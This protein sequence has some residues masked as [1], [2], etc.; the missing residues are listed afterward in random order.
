MTAE[1]IGDRVPLVKKM[2]KANHNHLERLLYSGFHDHSNSAVAPDEGIL[3]ELDLLKGQLSQVNSELY[4]SQATIRRINAE[5]ELKDADFAWAKVEEQCDT[6]LLQRE[7][8][9]CRQQ[10]TNITLECE[11]AVVRFSIVFFFYLVPNSSL[12][13]SRQHIQS[14][15]DRM[16]L[17]FGESQSEISE[18]ERKIA[19]QQ[20]TIEEQQKRL[21]MCE[22]DLASAKEQIKKYVPV[23]SGISEA[24]AAMLKRN[25]E[26]EQALAAQKA[27]II[28][29]ENEKTT[30]V[31]EAEQTI[32]SLQQENIKLQTDLA[33]VNKSL[34]SSQAEKMLKKQNE[35]SDS[36]IIALQK[37][38]ADQK[39]E[40]MAKEA[41]IK[42]LKKKYKAMSIM[43]EQNLARQNDAVSD[44]EVICPFLSRSM[45]LILLHRPMNTILCPSHK[46][47]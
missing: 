43:A 29:L 28:R 14:E 39:S 41:E 34:A 33:A 44:A 15:L 11:D 32:S 40:L 31:K 20:A 5:L 2:S 42:S 18:M 25:N 12:K 7:L 47:K 19:E 38:V 6:K 17:Y 10:I 3:H 4:T 27:Q 22:S 24:E 8:L 9:Q 1:I 23:L 26:Y 30:K 13:A 36:S 16:T 35:R 46:M 45:E 37:E 21:T